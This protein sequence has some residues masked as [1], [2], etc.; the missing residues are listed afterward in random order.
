M[1]LYKIWITFV[2][3]GREGEFVQETI[4]LERSNESKIYFGESHQFI[5]TGVGSYYS[6]GFAWGLSPANLKDNITIL[7]ST[8]NSKLFHSEEF[9][10]NQKRYV[11]RTVIDFTRDL[12]NQTT[13]WCFG[14][15]FNYFDWVNCTYD[16]TVYG[17]CIFQKKWKHYKKTL[18]L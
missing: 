4:K 1:L 9:D 10:T 17:N 18:L 8:N 12:A 13:I 14:P 11:V 16:I 7:S 5:C 6:Y 2:G 15:R 3:L